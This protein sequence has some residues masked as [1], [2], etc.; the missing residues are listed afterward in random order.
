MQCLKLHRAPWMIVLS[1]P[2]SGT[3]CYPITPP[4]HTDQ[5]APPARDK[6][7]CPCRGCT[8]TSCRSGCSTCLPPAPYCRCRGWA[9]DAVQHDTLLVQLD[10]RLIASIFVAYACTISIHALLYLYFSLFHFFQ[11]FIC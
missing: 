11:F 6:R 7:G 5:P 2:D 1:V 3:S 10:S 9:A 8:G 4:S